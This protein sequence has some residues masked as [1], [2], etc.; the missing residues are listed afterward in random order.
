MRHPTL[1]PAARDADLGRLDDIIAEL[2]SFGESGLLK[3]H[4]RSARQYLFG[5]MPEE[6]LVNLESARRAVDSIPDGNLQRRTDNM[7]AELIA[8][9]NPSGE[10][11]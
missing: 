6:Y 10:T 2:E 11:N 3:E 7:I 5:A 9:I 8:E 1:S 4:L